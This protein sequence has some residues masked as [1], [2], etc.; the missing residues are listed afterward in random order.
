MRMR[1]TVFAGQPLVMVAIALH[2]PYLV[3]PSPTGF[4]YLRRALSQYRFE[5]KTSVG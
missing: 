5:T 2:S 3:G 1:R 4:D